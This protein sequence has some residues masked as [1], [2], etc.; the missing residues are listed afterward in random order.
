MLRERPWRCGR[1]PFATQRLADRPRPT[2]RH[3]TLR[4]RP[5]LRG[6]PRCLTKGLL[7]HSP[8]L[9]LLELDSGAACFR[10]TDGNRLL[11]RPRPVLPLPDVVH[12]LTH[13]LAGLGGGSLPFSCV[14]TSTLDRRLLGH[15]DLPDRDVDP[16]PTHARARING[17]FRGFTATQAA[18]PGRY[19]ELENR[20]LKWSLLQQ[21][22]RSAS[23]QRA[24][25]RVA[26][27]PSRSG[28]R[29]ATRST[30]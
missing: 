16:Q 19:E 11:G 24:P 29:R 14:F 21:S 10:E 18:C 28:S 3:G 12:L 22:R 6:V 15:R 7:G 1:M 20:Q 4:A 9:R 17:T 27:G 25:H 2:R 30:P 26:R 8:A 13:E 5:S 23:Q